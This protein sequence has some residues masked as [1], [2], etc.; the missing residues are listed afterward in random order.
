MA[1][2]ALGCARVGTVGTRIGPESSYFKTWDMS[3]LVLGT[4]GPCLFQITMCSSV[5]GL[6]AK[7]VCMCLRE[8]NSPQQLAQG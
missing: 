7:P 3:P 8:H 4:L 5:A 6:P 1:A 2:Q